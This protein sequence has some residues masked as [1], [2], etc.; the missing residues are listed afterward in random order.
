M[1]KYVNGS[2]LFSMGNIINGCARLDS[3]YKHHI[4]SLTVPSTENIHIF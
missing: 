3:A 1:T 2:P 4:I